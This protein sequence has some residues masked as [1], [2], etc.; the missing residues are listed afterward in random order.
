M[1]IGKYRR[2]ENF[3]NEL[4]PGAGMEKGPENS[5]YCAFC[6]ELEAVVAVGT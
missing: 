4:N 5:F 1:A 6:D 2:E 3:K